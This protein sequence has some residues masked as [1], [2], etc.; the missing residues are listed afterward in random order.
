MFVFVGETNDEPNLLA[1]SPTESR[2]KKGQST[3]RL[4]RLY[5]RRSRCFLFLA[6]VFA[7]CELENN[8]DVIPIEIFAGNIADGSARAM[9]GWMCRSCRDCNADC[10]THSKLGRYKCNV[11]CS[12]HSNPGHVER[13]VYSCTERHLDSIA[14]FHTFTQRYSHPRADLNS[15]NPANPN[16]AS[17]AFD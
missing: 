1:A 10:S 11:D 15:Y 4:T 14:E 6:K 16:P 3:C 5:A 13:N 17:C 9:S 8:N 7:S 2:S 12:T